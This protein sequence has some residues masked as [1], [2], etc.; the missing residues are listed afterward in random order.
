MLLNSLQC[1]GQLPQQGS[2]CSKVSIMLKLRN[3]GLHGSAFGVGSVTL[4]CQDSESVP[5]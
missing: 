4:Q 5:L 2:I 1:T 3:P